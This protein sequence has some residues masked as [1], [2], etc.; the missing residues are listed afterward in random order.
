MHEY[1]VYNNIAYNNSYL[2]ITPCVKDPCVFLPCLFYV[3][4]LSEFSVS[5]PNSGLISTYIFTMI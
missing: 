5:N 2:S 1:T 3:T 4:F